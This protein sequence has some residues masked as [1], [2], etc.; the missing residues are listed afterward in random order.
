MIRVTQAQGPRWVLISQCYKQKA[1]KQLSLMFSQRANEAI[2]LSDPRQETCQH[3]KTDELITANLNNC[4]TCWNHQ[5]TTLKTFEQS[6]E[7]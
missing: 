7:F 3:W 2:Y 1:G 4:T 6:L 5:R